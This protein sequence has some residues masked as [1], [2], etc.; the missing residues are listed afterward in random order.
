MYPQA[1]VTFSRKLIVSTDKIRKRDLVPNILS[2]SSDWLGPMQFLTPGI[3]LW[4]SCESQTL[5]TQCYNG[6][7][8]TMSASQLQIAT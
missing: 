1:S 6:K 3:L 2:F 7:F 4:F 5:A 8:S